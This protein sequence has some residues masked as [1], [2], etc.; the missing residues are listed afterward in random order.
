M[1]RSVTSELSCEVA[2]FYSRR[3][4]MASAVEQMMSSFNPEQ[5]AAY[6]ELKN[7]VEQANDSTCLRFL[8]GKAGRG[9]T[10]VMNCLITLF[11]SQGA[12]VL[13]VGSTTL[14][15]IHYDCGRTAYSTFG[16]PVV[17]VSV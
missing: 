3:S 12:T 1:P 9:K 13:V 6:Q 7:A 2:A 5:L 16:I 10:F 14:S 8:D 17:E 11:R 15:I 4:E